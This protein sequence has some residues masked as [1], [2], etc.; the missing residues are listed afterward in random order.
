MKRTT[1][2]NSSYPKGGVSCSKDRFV[3]NETFV[4]LINICGKKPAHRVAANRYAQL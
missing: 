2:Y 4:L 1:G 3:V